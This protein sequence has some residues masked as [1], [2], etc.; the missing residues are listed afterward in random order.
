MARTQKGIEYPSDY[1][2][3][4][5]IPE[6]M[7]DMAESIDEAIPTKLSDL[8]NDSNFVEDAS[9]VHTDNNYTTTE[10]NK[11]AELENYDDSEIKEDIDNLN[12]GITDLNNNK[13]DKTEIPAKTSDLT[14]DSNYVN[15][16]QM[17]QAI[18]TEKTNRENSD[19]AL[20]NQIDAITVSSDVVD[21]VGTYTELQN[22][23]TT[24]L[25]N[26]D[27]IKVLQDSTHNDAMSYYRWVI[28]NNVGSW[29]YVG[30]EGPFYTKSENDEKLQDYVKNTDYATSSKGGVV[31]SNPYFNAL[32]S[33]EGLIYSNVNTYQEYGNK[34]EKAFICK[35]TL[36]NVIDNSIIL[37]GT[38]APTTSTVGHRIGQLY[39]NT[40]DNKVYQLTAIDNDTYTW[41]QLIRDNDY[42]T[43]SKGGTLKVYDFYAT[44]IYNGFLSS[45]I[46]TFSKY[47]SDSQNI[48][49][50]KGTLE[51]VIA[52]KQLVNKTYVDDIVG[53]IESLLGGI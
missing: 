21:I 38:T 49:I 13:A 44:E 20:Q 45:K 2:E 31:K 36:E 7:K 1:S 12:T 52:G 53:D 48:F 42:A 33:N 32:V 14:N 24:K 30:S 9:Y 16:T 28:T 22:Y 37:K 19:V 27:L 47:N 3:I 6:V 46:R 11:L 23:D 15:A 35:G 50:S 17:Q 34:D 4:A 26:D 41:Q 18:E 43:T 40:T 51:N 39:L 8:T 29:D 25:T 5:D 10:K